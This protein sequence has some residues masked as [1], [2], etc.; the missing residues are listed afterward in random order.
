MQSMSDDDDDLLFKMRD[1][2][3]LLT[4]RVAGRSGCSSG[5]SPTAASPE[6]HLTPTHSSEPAGQDEDADQTNSVLT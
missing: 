1:M 6:V 3:L 4:S 2:T 5:I